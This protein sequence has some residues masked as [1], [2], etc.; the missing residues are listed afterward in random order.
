M[1]AREIM[2]APVVSV[3]P[4]LPVTEASNLLAQRGFT[5][6]PV[7]N[8]DGRLIGIVTEADLLR[9]GVEPDPR[10][11]GFTPPP[12]RIGRTRTVGDV[13]TTAV[14]SFTP[15]ADVADIAR[16]MVAER[17]RCFPIVDG[18]GVVG[19]VTR[20]DL[21]RSSLSHSDLELQR[22]VTK[23]LA[24]LDDADRWQVT[25][26]AGVADVQDFRDSAGDRGRARV[27]A[28]SVPGVVAASVRQQTSDPF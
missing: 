17:I 5:A 9:D 7:L 15:G 18:V 6:V 12:T 8:D 27:A 24:A 21:L 26:Q 23:A 4:D 3:S 19:V 16:T 13:M 10:I 2:S 20:R 11:H 1:R 25:V 28:E 22:D 14:E